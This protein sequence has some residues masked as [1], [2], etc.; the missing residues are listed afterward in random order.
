MNYKK[1]EKYIE[2]K[3]LSLIGNDKCADLTC[4]SSLL[5]NHLKYLDCYTEGDVNSLKFSNELKMY[6]H[7]EKDFPELLE[8]NK[9]T[10]GNSI[11][12]NEHTIDLS[13]YIKSTNDKIYA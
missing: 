9:I 4:H 8:T 7:T 13:E 10:I 11:G 12:E 1:L 5:N 6:I 3:S 2:E